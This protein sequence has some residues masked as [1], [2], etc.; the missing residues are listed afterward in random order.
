[1][2]NDFSVLMLVYAGDRPEHFD[3]A[4]RSIAGQTLPPAEIVLVVDGPVSDGTEEVIRKYSEELASGGTD[5]RVI[6]SETNL[7][8]GGAKR[9]GFGECRYPL[10]AMMDADDVSVPDRFEK[11]ALKSRYDILPIIRISPSLAD[12]LRNLFPRRIPRIFPGR[13][14]PGRFRK[15]TRKSG[16]T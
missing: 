5:F 13:P 11:I 15:P 4:L 2:G 9:L 7:G 6:R 12:I 8:C 1:M 10:I 14:A 3:L 16:N